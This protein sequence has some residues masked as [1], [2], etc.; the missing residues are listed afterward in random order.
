VGPSGKYLAALLHPPAQ[1]IGGTL[2]G[3]GLF[4][5]L[6]S[7]HPLSSQHQFTKLKMTHDHINI[8]KQRLEK[9]Q[10]LILIKNTKKYIV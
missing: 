3:H 5:S 10:F 8:V 6:F 9:N 1:S 7:L 4:P 2:A